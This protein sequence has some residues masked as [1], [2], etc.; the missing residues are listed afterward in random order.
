MIIYSCR[1]EEFLVTKFT[2]AYLLI[3]YGQKR[4]DRREAVNMHVRWI[5]YMYKI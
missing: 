1:F 5:L 2:C 3:Y 4:A